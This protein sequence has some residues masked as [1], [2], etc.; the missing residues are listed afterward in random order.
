MYGTCH[1]YGPMVPRALRSLG[2]CGGP[3]E[4]AFSCERGAPVF[5]R[6]LMSEVPL[7]SVPG[8]H[9]LHGTCHSRSGTSGS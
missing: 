1:A 8:E 2:S 9:L 5:A 7:Y 4:G 3:R 6:F